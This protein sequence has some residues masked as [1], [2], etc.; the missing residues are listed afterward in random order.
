M[1]RRCT[2]KTPPELYL[3]IGSVKKE[4]APVAAWL[5][6]LYRET[7]NNRDKADIVTMSRVASTWLEMEREWLAVAL[8]KKDPEKGSGRCE[9]LDKKAPAKEAVAMTESAVETPQRSSAQQRRDADDYSTSTSDEE[10]PRKVPPPAPKTMARTRKKIEVPKAAETKKSPAAKEKAEEM[11]EEDENENKKVKTAEKNEN[12]DEKEKP[13]RKGP[14]KKKDRE[15][16]EKEKPKG[17]GP[18]K[19]KYVEDEG[20]E[21][22]KRRGPQKKKDDKDDGKEKPKRKGLQKTKD[23]F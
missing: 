1:L 10:P 21:K 16:E 8:G 5:T 19:K 14:I 12:E 3:T 2:S 22:P 13:K 17:R 7:P 4:K 20:K 9:G 15:D 18:Q 23:D 11:G 6:R